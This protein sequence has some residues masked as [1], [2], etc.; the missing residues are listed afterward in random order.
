MGKYGAVV[1]GAISVSWQV[2]S[3][4]VVKVRFLVYCSD[5]VN[6]LRKQ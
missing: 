4:D 6:D 2:I 5:H 3:T 1:R